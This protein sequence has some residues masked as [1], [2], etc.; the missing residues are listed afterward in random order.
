[1]HA[2]YVIIWEF[3]VAPGQERSFEKTYGRSGPWT[4]LLA[5]G[6]GHLGSELLTCRDE[7]DRYVTI[8]R[9]TSL[10]AYEA[11]HRK[12]ASAYAKLDDECAGLTKRE[13]RVGQFDAADA[14]V[15]VETVR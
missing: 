8:D 5:K 13:T 2:M 4:R 6:E 9:W 3:G 1:M 7:P 14:K 10:A 11:F 15:E 12:Y